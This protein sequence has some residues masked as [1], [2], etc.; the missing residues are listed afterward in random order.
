[1]SRVGGSEAARGM[2]ATRLL[3]SVPGRR[4]AEERVMGKGCTIATAGLTG[5]RLLGREG[6]G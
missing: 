1:M 4:A 3:T 2:D 6:G 5:I